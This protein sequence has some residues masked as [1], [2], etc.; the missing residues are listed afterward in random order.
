MRQITQGDQSEPCAICL[1]DTAANYLLPPTTLHAVTI[2]IE[3]LS[4]RA[5]LNASPTREGGRVRQSAGALD[6][7]RRSARF[8]RVP[9][10]LFRVFPISLTVRTKLQQLIQ[11]PE[12]NECHIQQIQ[13]RKVCASA[14]LGWKICAMSKPSESSVTS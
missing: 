11:M 2:I 14:F 1:E 7:Q 8:S 5:N 6:S 3:K 12:H 10:H 9:P 13:A 4:G